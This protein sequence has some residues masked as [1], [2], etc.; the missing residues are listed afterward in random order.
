MWP[1]RSISL[2][3]AAM[4]VGLVVCQ[5][6]RAQTR[7]LAVTGATLIDGSGAPPRAGVTVLVRDGVI[8][9]VSDSDETVIPPEADV[10]DAAGKYIVPGLAD[11]HV[12]FGTGGL[13]PT[14]A[15][16]R[17]R[18]LRQ[19]LFYGVTTV[20]NLG[21]TEGGM[22]DILALRRR[23]AAGGLI[24]PNVY[25]TGGLLTVPGSH[26]VATV[27]SVP[28]GQD[29]ATYDWSERGVWI[30]RSPD[31]VRDIVNR[32]A[33]AGM[34]GIKVVIESGFGED[35][36]QMPLALVEAAVAAAAERE[37]PVFAHANSP[38][39]LEIAV[40]AGVHAVVHL[41]S[42][43]S[44]VRPD[45][46]VA[47]QEQG[48][49]YVPTLSVYIW[50]DAWGD[51]EDTLTDPFLR[52]GVE[53]RVIESLL[54]SPMAPTT[55]PS[56]EDW[57]GRQQVLDA[58]KAA[59]DAGVLI[60]AG[61]DT[62]NPFVFPGHS[63]HHELALMVEAGL[64]PMEALVAATSRAA[65]MLGD[66]SWGTVAPGKRAD[67]LI[68]GADPLDDIRNTQTLETVV[69]NGEVVERAALLST[70]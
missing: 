57:A 60:A 1:A 14:D 19:F 10:I 61:S 35:L 69:L 16:A 52:S 47:M 64:T 32:L 40:A 11:M 9:A 55:P 67:L 31:E 29:P 13:L 5:T 33:D 21:A 37:I 48:I 51:P 45:L 20:L 43:R 41:V 42:D 28:E 23:S 36:P 12:H 38:H 59:S 6:A 39:E 22:E 70:E 24:A 50:T 49:Y 58:L 56:E 62:N 2:T 54:S 25:A 65:E 8:A 3:I 15:R 30:V 63:T 66:D 17:E 27:M 44:P 7:P 53:P 18:A 68:L 26:P 46:L 4:M 34:E